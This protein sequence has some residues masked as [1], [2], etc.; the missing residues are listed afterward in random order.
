MRRD[1]RPTARRRNADRRATLEVSQQR[2]LKPLRRR[3]IE[4]DETRVEIF[5]Q[6]FQRRI[7]K[8]FENRPEDEIRR[9]KKRSNVLPAWLSALAV[10]EV[11]KFQRQMTDAIAVRAELSDAIGPKFRQTTIIAVQSR[12]K[13]FVD[14]VE[15]SE[16][17]MS[18][19]T[20]EQR[21]LQQSAH[22][23]ER[24]ATRRPSVTRLNERID[25]FAVL[26]R[27][28]EGEFFAQNFAFASGTQEERQLKELH[29]RTL[30]QLL[31]R[32]MR[33]I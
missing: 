27:V 13:R 8:F 10:P 22:G 4:P 25:A 15:K 14:S 3:R 20:A 5:L 29:E 23:V 21:E 33:P 2:L 6:M 28:D 19:R 16:G 7:V 24:R 18:L 26:H 1:D 9:A 31:D 12:T 30:L 17:E 11:R 32:Q